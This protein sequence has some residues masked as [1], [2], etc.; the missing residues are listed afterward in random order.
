MVPTSLITED[1]RRQYI[2][3]T[4]DALILT[5]GETVLDCNVRAL[6]MFRWETPDEI[7]GLPLAKLTVDGHSPLDLCDDDTVGVLS[8]THTDTLRRASGEHFTAILSVSTIVCETRRCE[9]LCLRD[10]T[11]RLAMMESGS[12]LDHAYLQ[13]LFEHSPE[14]IVIADRNSRVLQVNRRF[15]DMFGYDEQQAV[16]EDVDDLIVPPAM[17]EEASD[18]TQTAL[19]GMEAERQTLR[20]RKDGTL[21]PVS[22][23]AAPI[24]LN[25]SL[26][27]LY[28]IY[29]DISKLRA[30]E[31]QLHQTQNR[32]DAII[33]QAPIAIFTLD[34]DGYFTFCAGRAIQQVGLSEGDLIGKSTFDLFPDLPEALSATGQALQGHS[35]MAVVEFRG[36]SFEVQY[37]PIKDADGN[38][39]S[40]VGVARDVTDTILA[41]KQLEFMAHHDI[42][43]GL[44]NRALFQERVQ[45]AIRRAKRRKS[46]LAVLFIDLDRFKTINDTLGHQMGDRVIQRA[47]VQCASAIREVD[48]VARLGGD[49][50][51]VLLED[52]DSTKGAETVAQRILDAVARPYFEEDRDLTVRGSVG[53][54]LYP[55]HGLDVETLIKHADAAMYKAKESGRGRFE[56][57]RPEMQAS[58]STEFARTEL[59]RRAL[60][61]DNFVLHYQPS[62]GAEDLAIAGIEALVRLRQADGHLMPPLE[63][64][65][66]AEETGLIVPIG[67]WVLEEACRQL[68]A[69]LMKGDLKLRMAINLSA[70]QFRDK[71][72]LQTISDTLARYAIPPE[73]FMVEITESMMFP[74]PHIAQMTLSE[75]RAMNIA[76]SIDDFGTGFSSLS[77]L[78]DFSVDYIKIDRTFIAGTPNDRKSCGIT[79]TILSLARNLDMGVIAEGVETAAQFNFLKSIGCDEVQGYFFG[80]PMDA[81]A[82]TAHFDKLYRVDGKPTY[83][84]EPA[85]SA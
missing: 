34:K 30:T 59:L 4:D 12:K 57:Y 53:V 69:W 5:D 44:P 19:I 45:D 2:E 9:V 11:S 7:I 22:I 16:G 83:T 54:S 1:W 40:I 6:H 67:Q 68:N 82:L 38:V 3:I 50:F 28:V 10:I 71:G 27:A 64:I 41:R 72:F 47:A 8:G 81:T 73:L 25:G 26:I 29:R 62:V 60:E 36:A 77:Y 17:R 52:L 15:C 20:Q 32:L 35:A 66:I 70:R 63:F 13:T 55:E 42:L 37:T 75:L 46:I 31:D 84:I 33:S 24:F 48:T 43:T 74:D 21:F 65:A 14:A 58:S 39:Q 85:S 78:K 56:V 76:V 80:R 61:Q 18:L 23:L 51:A 49:E 79:R